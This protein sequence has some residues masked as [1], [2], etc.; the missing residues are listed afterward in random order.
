MRSYP[1]PVT[2]SGTASFEYRDNITDG[3][4]A[5][6]PRPI[7]YHE[8]VVQDFEG[9]IIQ[10]GETDATG[11]FSLQVPKGSDIHWLYINSRANN[12]HL[13]AYVLNDPT[14][15]EHYS[16]KKA[17]T[18][19]TDLDFG[20]LVAPATG[21]LEGGA[22]HILDQILRA[23]EYLVAETTGCDLTFPGCRPFVVAD[24][25]L[26]TV[27]WKKGFNPGCYFS[28]C[29]TSVSFYLPTYHEM[30]LVG[31]MSGLV[32]T[33][34]AD[35]FDNTIILHE[36]AH[37]LEDVIA[38]SDSPGGQH[39]GN[40]II[41]PRLAWS[42]GFA[43]FFQATITGIPAYID[44]SGTGAYFQYVIDYPIDETY[45]P[46]SNDVPLTPGEGV[47]REFSVARLLW[48]VVHAPVGSFAEI[49][50]VLS[51]EDS[52]FADSSYKF[53]ELG[54]FHE[55]QR[56]LPAATDWSALRAAEL[57]S[58]YREHFGAPLIASACSI[59]MEDLDIMDNGSISKANPHLANDFFT[60]TH[61]GGPLTLSI[62]YPTGVTDPLDLDLYLYKPGYR[63]MEST[64]MNGASEELIANV[65]T[66]S[67]TISLS[68]L[69]AGTYMVNVRLYNG[70]QNIADLTEKRSV[71]KNYIRDALKDQ[72]S[73]TV[74][75]GGV[76]MCPAPDPN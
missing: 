11:A 61:T 43:N 58:G 55:L 15:N 63:Y 42:E 59:Q 2:I 14:E 16:L 54:L 28:Q 18:P 75:V 53:R 32:D 19:L 66:Q 10:C 35:H 31:G 4:I 44:T 9:R 72:R 13:K 65:A 7:R 3:S 51:K 21:T 1:D 26:L 50:A 30:Y 29:F 57:Q 70:P 68:S 76:P 33:V 64:T 69:A 71:S 6:L 25:P 52:G 62:S 73:Y 20:S 22:F 74:S 38:T 23:N 56:A 46:I 24:L 67:E 12:A 17:F 27:Y 39:N 48:D 36:Y 49:W 37:Y 41:D 60:L 45:S 8:I 34:D 5:A 40:Q 47:F